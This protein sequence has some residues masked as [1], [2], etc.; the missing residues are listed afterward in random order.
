MS[1][2]DPAGPAPERVTPR[3]RAGSLRLAADEAPA[4]RLLGRCT[5][6]GR[7]VF[8]RTPHDWANRDTHEPCRPHDTGATLY[9]SPCSDERPASAERPA[10]KR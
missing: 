2:S 9:C 6:C 4:T 8:D 7:L 1:L 3:A 5:G 10:P